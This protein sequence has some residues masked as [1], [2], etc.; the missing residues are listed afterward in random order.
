MN[1]KTYTARASEIERHLFVVD[2]TDQTLGRL[3][4]RVAFV[5]AGKHKPTWRRTSTAATT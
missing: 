5:L 4:T 1:D 3:A 2:A